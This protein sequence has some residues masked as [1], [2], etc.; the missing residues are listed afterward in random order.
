M[1]LR[2]R[3]REES[4]GGSF[5]L[6]NP[7]FLPGR[8]QGGTKKHAKKPPQATVGWTGLGGDIAY[9]IVY[10]STMRSPVIGQTGKYAVGKISRLQ[11]SNI[12]LP[13]KAS[14]NIALQQ[15]SG[16]WQ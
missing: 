9:S 11:R 5:S 1:I 6:L 15:S 12:S 10:R 13:E 7:F 16:F 4:C 3:R 2:I 14:R 8:H